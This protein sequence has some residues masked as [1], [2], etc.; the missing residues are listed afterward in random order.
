M[1]AV[2]DKQRK[3]VEKPQQRVLTRKSV[4][5]GMVLVAALAAAGASALVLRHRT[6]DRDVHLSL[7]CTP[8]EKDVYTLRYSSDG[9]LT[10]S[11]LGLSKSDSPNLSATHIRAGADGRLVSACVSTTAESYTMAITVEGARGTFET[12]VG[13]EPGSSKPVESLVMGTTYITKDA[14]GRTLGVRFDETM[15]ETGR[16]IVR[17]MLSLAQ[18]T[19]PKDRSTMPPWTIA[20]EDANGVYDAH[21]EVKDVDAD[22]VT[23]SKARHNRAPEGQLRNHARKPHADASSDSGGTLRVAK[24]SGRAESANVAVALD[25]RVG[26]HSV[27]RTKS[28]L[29]LVRTSTEKLSVDE[30]ASLV[31]GY[32]ER[33]ARGGATSDLAAHDLDAHLEQRMQER[34]LGSETWETLSKRIDDPESDRT[35]TFLK[36]KALFILQSERA[37]EAARALAGMKD[38][39]APSFLLLT[40]SLAASGTREAQKALV[41]AA[42]ASEPNSSRERSLVATLGTVKTPTPQTVTSLQQVQNGRGGEEIRGTARLALGSL[43]GELREKDP[44]LAQSV[45]NDN[46][47]SFRDAT[48]PEDRALALLALGNAGAPDNV[49]LAREALSD[50]DPRVRAAAVASLRFVMTME[51][52]TMLAG[53]AGQD[54][55]ASVRAEALRSLAVRTVGAETLALATH[56]VKADGDQ[57]VRMAAVLLLANELEQDP[58][59]A[60]VLE[61]VGR[62]DRAAGVRNAAQMALLR[63]G[64]I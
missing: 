6:L 49:A 47:Q 42:R 60:Q 12:R 62:T 18:L 30:L 48:T 2:R 44:A 17:D 56:V 20:E 58:S 9:E 1:K 46:V 19:L 21:Y 64:K 43:A 35:K 54:S 53:A 8:G 41:D 50:P 28:Q 25:L 31:R 7:G 33:E 38:A 52:E 22:T 34:E 14:T 55:S 16:A 57:E 5:V 10:D 36:L 40:G 11:S 15:E 23:L 29:S 24:T 13:G 39:Q 37:K 63:S 27:G 32:D 4:A 59:L 3:A 45:V 61:D 26:D 51:A